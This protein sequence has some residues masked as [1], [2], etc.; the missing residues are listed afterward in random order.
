MASLPISATVRKGNTRVTLGVGNTQS[1]F[2]PQKSGR[3]KNFFQVTRSQ[4]R[5]NAFCTNGSKGSV[6][7]Q[8]WPKKSFASSPAYLSQTSAVDLGFCHENSLKRTFV[9]S[10]ML[11]DNQGA[12]Q[13]LLGRCFV[14][15]RLETL[16]FA[17]YK[18]LELRDKRVS[19]YIGKV[20]FLVNSAWHWSFC[21]YKCSYIRDEMQSPH[22]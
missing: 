17:P 13:R 21:L 7:R 20:L 5:M 12:P 9:G 4:H 8:Q 16:D 11:R 6:R 2:L 15:K 22:F 14:V 3:Q 1:L 19:T 10:F 18:H